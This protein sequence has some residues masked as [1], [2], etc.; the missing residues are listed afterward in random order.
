MREEVNMDEQFWTMDEDETAL[1]LFALWK[2]RVLDK[3]YLSQ[4]ISDLSQRIKEERSK[5]GKES[6]EKT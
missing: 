2:R 1:T 5:W 4:R 6:E 3:T